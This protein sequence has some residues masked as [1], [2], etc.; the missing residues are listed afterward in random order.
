M[1]EIILRDYQFNAFKEMIFPSKG[2][3]VIPTGGGKTPLEAAALAAKL[4]NDI[5]NIGLVLAPRIV[6]IQ[7]LMHEYRQTVFTPGNVIKS[8]AGDIIFNVEKSYR[9]IAFHSGEHE[10]DY[11]EKWFQ[12]EDEDELK[13]GSWS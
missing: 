5:N 1:S 7:Q 9:F 3:I 2:R 11:K 10:P 8:S 13:E 6:L 12:V 4:G